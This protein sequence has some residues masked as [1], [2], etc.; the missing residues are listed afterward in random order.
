MTHESE[1]EV[2]RE[3][4]KEIPNPYANLMR[5]VNQSNSKRLR[6]SPLKDDDQV[7]P[8]ELSELVLRMIAYKQA[9]ARSQSELF[10]RLV[11]EHE[12][13][14]RTKLLNQIEDLR[15]RQTWID[16]QIYLQLHSDL[17][18][19]EGPPFVTFR[20]QKDGR[21][22]GAISATTKRTYQERLDELF[23]AIDRRME[24]EALGLLIDVAFES[25]LWRRM[26]ALNQ[27]YTE[28]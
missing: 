20:T 1:P 2:E 3:R 28:P 14:K 4:D 21:I 27:P 5:Q 8:G 9:L 22:V 25:E 13:K 12:T 24:K 26:E 10:D 17:P 16:T 18:P 11:H 6:F 7:L 23:E 19:W 15:V